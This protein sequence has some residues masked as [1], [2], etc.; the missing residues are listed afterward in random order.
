MAVK[1]PKALLKQLDELMRRLRSDSP[2]NRAM[3]TSRLIGYEQSGKIPLELLLQ[4]AGDSDVNYAMYAITALGR[5]GKPEAVVKLIELVS[6]HRDGNPL[7]LETVIEAL[8]ESGAKDAVPTLLQLIGITAPG[9]N[10][11]L[12]RITRRKDV[13]DQAE[14]QFR[15]SMVLPVTR[16]LEKIGDV[17]S[18]PLIEGYLSHE[19]PLVRCHTIRVLINAG[20]TDSIE[21]LKQIAQSDPDRL[22]QEL[23]AIA[24]DKLAP[25]PGNL[26]N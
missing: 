22:V 20:F 4:M 3:A 24:L 8:A 19:D 15:D 1:L 9:K 7:F 2:E 17:D 5:S 25:Q 23:A 18:A 26:N 21:R 16:A 6:S 14:E 10:R 13:P 12:S 11:F